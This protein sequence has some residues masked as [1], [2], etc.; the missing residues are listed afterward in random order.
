MKARVV[1]QTGIDRFASRVL[2]LASIAHLWSRGLLST[3]ALPSSFLGQSSTATAK[4]PE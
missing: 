4:K 3:R 1:G 2:D